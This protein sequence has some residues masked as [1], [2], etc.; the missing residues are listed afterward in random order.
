MLNCIVITA[1]EMSCLATAAEVSCLAT[2]AEVSLIT[3]AEV[4]FHYRC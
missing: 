4:Y 2:A 1:A 3:A